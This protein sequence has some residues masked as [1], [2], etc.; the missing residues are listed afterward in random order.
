M[1]AELDEIERRDHAARDRARGAEAG[2][3]RGQSETGCEAIEQRAGRAARGRPRPDGPAGSR[4]RRR[5][6]RIQ[7]DQASR[8]KPAG[9]SSSRPSAR[10]T[11][12]AR[13]ELR[14]RQL[15]EL[16]AELEAADAELRDASRRPR[17]LKEEVD[18]EDIAE[19]VA[20]LDRHPG[21]AAARGR[22][23]EAAQD[24]GAAARARHRPGRGGARR[25]SNAVR[26]A[27]AGLQ[28][29]NRPIGSFI[30]L[31]PTGVGKTE[32]AQGA[33]RVPVRR[34]ARDG[35]AST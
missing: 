32:L 6:A 16:R 12:S 19:V 11:W 34:R 33:G 2:D 20:P 21:H 24:G 28:D 26:R 22:G 27:R 30:F 13:P 18:E 25:S 14:V 10:P 9:A 15:P 29:P 23:R 4:R 7:R 17:M 5:S 3:G 31:G 8:S 35:P 1:P